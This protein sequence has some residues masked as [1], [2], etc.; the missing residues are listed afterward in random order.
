MY[1]NTK[2]SVSLLLLIKN[3]VHNVLKMSQNFATYIATNTYRSVT[4]SEQSVATR[5]KY[6]CV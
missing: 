1:F 6:V 2:S 4:Q 5:K 3:G